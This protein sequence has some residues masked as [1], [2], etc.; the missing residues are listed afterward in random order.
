MARR[1]IATHEFGTAFGIFAASFVGLVV[2][3][4]LLG[5]LGLPNRAGGVLL[6]AVTLIAFAGIGLLVRT[7]RRSD[8]QYGGRN[9]PALHNGMATA[10]AFLGAG[11]FLGLTGAFFAAGPG[12][13]AFILG[14]IG[15]FV[16]LTVAVA[17]YVRNSGAATLPDLYVARFGNGPIRLLAPLIVLAITLGLLVVNVGV[18][19][20]IAAGVFGI[21]RETAVVAVVAIILL[22]TLFGGMRSMTMSGVAQYIVLLI[23]FLTPLVA[24]ATRE[25]GMPLPQ[26]ALG[27]ALQRLADLPGDAAARLAASAMPGH[28][29]PAE[30]LGGLNFT[31]V[32]LTF[33]AGVAA[34]PHLV[35]RSIPVADMDG[36]RRSGAWGFVFAMLVVASAPVYAAFASLEILDGIAVVSPDALPGWVYSL[37][38][39]G[40]A[41]ACSVFAVSRDAVAAACGAGGLIDAASL[42]FSGD[43]VVL[44][45]PAIAGLRPVLSALI[46]VGAIAA[47]L[48]AATALL[49][50]AASAFGHDLYARLFE[51]HAPAGRRLIAI[52][53]MLIATAAFAGWAATRALDDVYPFAAVA[54]S[55]SAA[56]LFP[57]LILGIWWRRCTSLGALSGMVSGM[58]IALFYFLIVEYAGEAPWTFFGLSDAGVPGFAAGAFGLP[59]GLLVA[60][61][62]SLATPP[63]PERQA[64]LDRIRRPAS[65]AGEDD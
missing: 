55:L 33:A 3:V 1:Q 50:A 37:G 18:A 59:V 63:E 22:S 27:A 20:T 49:F 7:M 57:S 46:A 13:L 32:V 10:A 44:A 11:G 61:V 8:F 58:G 29:F 24:V 56:G 42:S 43:A 39:G 34:L 26:A 19:S 21:P 15:G 23:A 65:G 47:T 30:G 35:M 31:L 62:V 45:F 38:A 28:L 6:V 52:R 16:L 12:A 53:L 9:V 41:R 40:Q 2:I 51:P 36:A 5:Q 4:A 48:A 54:L 60:I 64:A 17:P 14:A 25:F